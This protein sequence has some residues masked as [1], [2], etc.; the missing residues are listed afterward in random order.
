MRKLLSFRI[1]LCNCFHQIFSHWCN[2]PKVQEDRFFFTLCCGMIS[3]VCNLR[4]HYFTVI[5]DN[6]LYEMGLSH[7]NKQLWKE[8]TRWCITTSVP[9][10]TSGLL[11]GR[12]SLM[13]PTLGGKELHHKTHACLQHLTMNR[14]KWQYTRCQHL[15]CLMT[16]GFSKDIWTPWMTMFIAPTNW[17]VIDSSKKHAPHAERNFL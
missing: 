9:C 10:F 14:A 12:R 4:C 17:V 1:S 11:A 6:P 7:A 15:C 3:G 13:K 5:F 8:I 2:I 16:P